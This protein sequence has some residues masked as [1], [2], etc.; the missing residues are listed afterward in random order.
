MDA[1][2]PRRIGPHTYRI[3]YVLPQLSLLPGRYLLRA[4]AMDSAGLRLFDTL[5]REFCSP[6]RQSGTRRVLLAA[7]VGN[8]TGGSG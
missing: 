5:E 1:A 3:D 8:L 6:G 2:V 4:H 7:R